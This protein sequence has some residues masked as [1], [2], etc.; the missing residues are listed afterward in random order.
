MNKK[1]SKLCIALCLCMSVVFTLLIPFGDFEYSA[2]ASSNSNRKELQTLISTNITTDI[3]KNVYGGKVSEVSTFTPFDNENKIRMAGNS[4]V[5]EYD[6]NYAFVSAKYNLLNNGGLSDSNLIALGMWI[7]FSDVYVHDL[8]ISLYVTE[9]D[10][11]SVT[12]SKNDMVNLCKKT[13]QITEQ[14]FAWNY[15]EIPLLSFVKYG[16]VTENNL[17]KNFKYVKIS[18]TSNEILQNYKYSNFRF[19]GMSLLSSSIK[20]ITISEKQDYT[21][22]AFNFWSDEIVDSI[23]LGDKVKTFALSDAVEYAWVGE[24]NLMS[25]KNIVSWQIVVEKPNGEINYYNFG[26]EITFDQAGSYT[27][28]YRASSTNSLYEFSLYDYIEI[29]VRDNNLIYFNFSN[30]KIE[31][32]KQLVLPLRLDSTLDINQVE[33]VIIEIEDDRIVEVEQLENFTFRV[34][35]LKTGKT[36]VTIKLMAKR[37]NSNEVIEY[38]TSVNLEVQGTESNNNLSVMI[39]IYTTLGIIGAFA[40]AFGVKAI[41]DSRRNDVR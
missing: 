27:L 1:I 26:D 6:E 25:M 2:N 34:N 23:I 21:T 16:Q 37:H 24:I 14:A 20:N 3:W 19:Y 7:Y 15:L 39:F 22:Y 35:S 18:Y 8:T 13:G 12:I 28:A 17:Y 41:V 40:I 33:D 36:K 10:Y 32:G 9:C 4:I 38:M 31:N 30:Y 29:N 5:P 11:M